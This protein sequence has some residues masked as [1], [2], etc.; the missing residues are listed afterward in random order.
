MDEVV[1]R[2]LALGDGTRLH[3]FFP[4]QAH[5]PA[6]EEQAHIDGRHAD[7]SDE[8]ADRGRDFEESPGR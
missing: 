1:D 6:P 7:H 4:I 2:L 5:V 8:C 3:V